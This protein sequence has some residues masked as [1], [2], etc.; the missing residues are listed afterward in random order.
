MA[1]E[2]AIKTLESRKA[3]I[4]TYYISWRR[5]IPIMKAY[6]E[7]RPMY[8]ATREFQWMLGVCAL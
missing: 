6:E 4:G 8:F 3:P 5:W 1:S 2:R 7:G